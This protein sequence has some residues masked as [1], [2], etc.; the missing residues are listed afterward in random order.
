VVNLVS[1]NG[2]WSEIAYWM[3]V[4]G[5]IGG[6]AAALFG[7]IDWTKIPAGTRA[8]RIGLLHG[9]GNVGVVVLFVASWLLRRDDPRAP[10]TLALV[11]S[12]A[13]A[14]LSL[15]TGWLGGELVDRLAI[16]VD[17]GAHVDAPSSLSGRPARDFATASRRG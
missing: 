6:L 11:L 17:E 13:G 12:F 3:I 8:W 1:G 7:L 5:V 2:Y 4:A 10:E 9:V 15:V 16:G 14:G